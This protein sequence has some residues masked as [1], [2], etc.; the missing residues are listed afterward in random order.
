MSEQDIGEIKEKFKPGIDNLIAG[1][2]IG[3][4]MIGGGCA[5]IWFSVRGIIRSPVPVPFFAER[6]ECW[7]ATILFVVLGVGLIVGGVFLIKGMRSLSSLRVSV[8]ANGF[9]V[10][11]RSATEFFAWDEIDAVQET[12]LFERPPVL[13]GVAK[14]ALPKVMS[15]S[16]RVEMRNQESFGFDATSIKRHLDLAKMIKEQADRRN[17]PWTIVEEHR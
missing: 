16:F 9:A 7:A 13:K 15:Q 3:L 12:H 6:G 11:R 2:I 5:A 4:L 14:Y 1:V 17:L 8:G 10:T